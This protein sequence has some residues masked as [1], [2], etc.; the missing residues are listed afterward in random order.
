MFLA[1]GATSNYGIGAAVKSSAILLDA[2]S[3]TEEQPTYAEILIGS[4]LYV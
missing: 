1:C 3:I 2:Y 4:K